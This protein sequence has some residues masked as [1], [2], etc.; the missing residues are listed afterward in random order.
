M[1]AS[2]PSNSRRGCRGFGSKGESAL[3]PRQHD[4]GYST[5]AHAITIC[6]GGK[7]RADRLGHACAD[8]GVGV[9]Q[10]PFD[11]ANFKHEL[12]GLIHTCSAAQAELCLIRFTT[13]L[14][15]AS[16]FE[17]GAHT[18]WVGKRK[19]SRRARWERG[20]WSDMLGRCHER[21][22]N[23]LVLFQRLPADKAEP[24]S[25]TQRC[26]QVAKR[27]RR[28]VEEHDAEARENQ[29]EAFPPERVHLGIG[30]QQC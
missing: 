27:S 1:A 8:V 24:S 6:V 18:L 12:D 10:K 4:P 2:T 14:L 3:W 19:R 15:E 23:P 26:A 5:Q 20:R 17:E 21:D 16:R 7:R 30:T 25:G 13:Y 28:V 29:I 9:V 22:T 11:H